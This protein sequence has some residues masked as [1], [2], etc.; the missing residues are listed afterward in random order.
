MSEY[1][2]FEFQAIDRPLT[3]SEMRELRR[4]SSRATIT[5]TSFVNVYNWGDFKGDR[6]VWMEKYFDA[7]LYVANW[8]SHRLEL[9]LPKRLLDPD[10][11]SAYCTEEILYC[12][13]KGG[14]VIVSFD[15]EDESGEWAEGEGWLASLTPLRA[16]LMLGDHRCL[17]LGWLMAAQNGYLEEDDIEPPVPPGLGTLS[18]PLQA[19]VDFLRIDPNWIVAAAEESGEANASALKRDE[20]A[21]WVAHLP[22]EEKDAALMALIDG[23]DMHFATEFTQHAIREIRNARGTDGEGH[24]NR[25]RRSVD[26]LAARA[27]AIAQVRRAR[28]TEVRERAKAKRERDAAEERKKH[29]ESLVGKED[30]L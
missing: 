8:G 30:L 18:S 2:Y 4:Y 7:F 24:L 14:F 1:Q 19:L 16:D 26:D 11:V 21:A 12:H 3:D 25:K 17:Y 27:D 13:A 15:S 29:I 9:R 10:T 20:I 22:L 23:D 28:E 6:R 5:P